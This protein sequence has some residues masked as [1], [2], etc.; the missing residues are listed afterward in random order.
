MD[1]WED[2]IIPM[3]ADFE[4]SIHFTFT[5]P[6]D[7]I[8]SGSRVKP[9]TEEVK[10]AARIIFSKLESFGCKLHRV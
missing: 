9:A 1:Q 4:R 8:L 6:P 2:H 10:I 5:A 3:L 7:T